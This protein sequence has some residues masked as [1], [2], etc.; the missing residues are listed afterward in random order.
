[1]FMNIFSEKEGHGEI[2]INQQD[3]VCGGEVRV[4]LRTS[5]SIGHR[6]VSRGC[7]YSCGMVPNGAQEIASLHSRHQ[8]GFRLSLQN[9]SESNSSQGL[10]KAGAESK[11]FED[12]LLERSRIREIRDW[13]GSI[14]CNLSKSISISSFGMAASGAISSKTKISRAY[15]I[16]THT[17]LK[18][19]SIQTISSVSTY[20]IPRKFQVSHQ[21]LTQFAAS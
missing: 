1:M 17:S 6:K 8:Q 19:S 20:W 12:E 15:L 14:D 21:N 2:Q 10:R 3:L 5:G 4:E 16:A 18:V 7:A 11:G 9:A 13:G